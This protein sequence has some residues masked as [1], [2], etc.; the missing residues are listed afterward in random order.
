MYKL[1]ADE[2]KMKFHDESA[3]E[4]LI[5]PII[6]D[7]LQ[8]CKKLS[9]SLEASFSATAASVAKWAHVPSLLGIAHLAC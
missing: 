7:F 3:F 8:N 4:K 9:A 2:N 1:I 5:L 6:I